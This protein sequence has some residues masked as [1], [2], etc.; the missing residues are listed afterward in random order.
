LHDCFSSKE[1]I[2]YDCLGIAKEGSAQE[3][4]GRQATTLGSDRPVINQSGGQISRSARLTRLCAPL[5]VAAVG[6]MGARW[7]QND[8]NNGG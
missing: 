1:L 5:A 3:L 4:I 8:R 7:R 6:G 2:T